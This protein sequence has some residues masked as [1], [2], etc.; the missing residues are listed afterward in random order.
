MNKDLFL[1]I[2]CNLEGHNSFFAQK[3]NALGQP[4]LYPIQKIAS[5]IWMLA[6]G[7]AADSNNKYLWISETTIWQSWVHFCQGMIEIYGKQYLWLPNDHNLQFLL[8]IGKAW[9]LPGMLGSI[10]CMHWPWKNCPTAWAGQYQGKEKV[11]TIVLEAVVSQDLWFWHL[12]FGLPGSHN[13][14][15]ILDCS[16][17][18]RNLMNGTGPEVEFWVNGNTYKNGYYLADG[19]YPNWG[20]LLKIISQPQDQKQNFF[21]K[22]QEAAWRDVERAFGV[23]QGCF[24]IVARPACGWNNH[25]LQLIMSTCVIL[26]NM[27]VEDEHN[28]ESDFFYGSSSVSESIQTSWEPNGNFTSVVNKYW[29]IW[30]EDVHQ[31]LCRDVIEQLWNLKGKID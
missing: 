24:A 15:N 20:A 10:E 3:P 17:L 21:E 14:I 2:V 12:F 29:E 8:Q 22:M 1:K 19:I 23:L 16:P 9:G 7:N 25:D 31:S 13:N 5:S 4:G 28:T 6:Y 11:L 18:F 26:H 30:N 27:I